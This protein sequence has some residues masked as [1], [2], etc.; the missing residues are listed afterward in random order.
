MD[1]NSFGELSVAFALGLQQDTLFFL[2]TFTHHISLSIGIA[3]VLLYFLYRN[4]HTYFLI[5][6]S[7]S[8][9]ASFLFSC[10]L[11]L[12]FALDFD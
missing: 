8:F 5:N 11:P 7:P 2:Q 10:A 3:N 6:F 12:R 4:H 9:I 1:F